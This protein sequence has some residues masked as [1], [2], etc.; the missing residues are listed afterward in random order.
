M[1]CFSF[2][3]HFFHFYRLSVPRRPAAGD[4]CVNGSVAA[5]HPTSGRSLQIP[6]CLRGASG[7]SHLV[8][9][10]LRSP[11]A[12]RRLTPTH[13][14][15]LEATC[16]EREQGKE[17]RKRLLGDVGDE[18]KSWTTMT[19][20]LCRHNGP[21][22]ISLRVCVGCER[23]WVDADLISPPCDSAA[24]LFHSGDEEEKE[25]EGAAE[26]RRVTNLRLFFT[27]KI[28]RIRG[29]RIDYFSA[30]GAL[31]PALKMKIKNK[32]LPLQGY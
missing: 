14:D 23:M 7:D 24:S 6:I 29:A 11:A 5:G 32:T 26:S 20:I 13:C 3:S 28:T 22:P 15:E 27:N 30:C 31:V 16:G 17:G 8:V 25:E 10:E 12:L 19:L 1:S 18:A 9:K 4:K 2:A 21:R